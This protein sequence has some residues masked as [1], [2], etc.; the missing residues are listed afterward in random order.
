MMWFNV[1]NST[2]SIF[3]HVLQMISINQFNWRNLIGYLIV[4]CYKLQCL[5]N[6]SKNFLNMHPVRNKHLFDIPIFPM[7]IGFR[8]LLVINTLFIIFTFLVIQLI[9]LLNDRMYFFVQFP[10]STFLSQINLL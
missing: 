10:L 8:L 1:E 5:F 9:L 4:S 6:L 3:K 7:R 2:F